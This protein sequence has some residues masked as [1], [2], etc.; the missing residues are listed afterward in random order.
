[1]ALGSASAAA[2]VKAATAASSDH[3]LGRLE[4]A[5]ARDSQVLPTGGAMD[6]AGR[7]R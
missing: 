3:F 5:E 7:E 6:H 4:Q 2:A 1:M